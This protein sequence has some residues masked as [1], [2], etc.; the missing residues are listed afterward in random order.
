M[1]ACSSSSDSTPAVDVKSNMVGKYWCPETTGLSTYYFKSDGTYEQA[2]QPDY[3]TPI[4]DGKWTF[5]DNT[6]NMTPSSGTGAY[7]I[8]ITK[9][10]ATSVTMEFP[11]FGI[12]SN[13]TICK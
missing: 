10:T 4:G 9:S 7:I 5:S 11:V 12:T 1:G 8:K 6:F 3:K 13:Y 2:V